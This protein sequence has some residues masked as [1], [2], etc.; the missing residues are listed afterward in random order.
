MLIRL[1]SSPPPGQPAE[2]RAQR[3][4]RPS[5]RTVP[6]S[7][8][9]S[10]QDTQL[11]PRTGAPSPAAFDALGLTDGQYQAVYAGIIELVTNR[12]NE[13]KA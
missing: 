7:R 8:P 6:S 10:L 3:P 4:C 2:T 5:P 11:D 1:V 12:K 13:S 9:G